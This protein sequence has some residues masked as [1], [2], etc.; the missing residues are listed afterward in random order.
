MDAAGNVA[1]SSVLSYLHGD[2]S[3]DAGRAKAR[4]GAALEALH[5]DAAD[6]LLRRHGRS[7][8]DCQVSRECAG[9]DVE[10]DAVLYVVRVGEG[11]DTYALNEAL[12][13]LQLARG[14]TPSAQ[15]DVV[16]QP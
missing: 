15:L 9:L 10:D 14:L 12:T 1:R 7:L 13:A 3:R 16:F 6:A 11:F 5:L 4:D 2:A 8:A